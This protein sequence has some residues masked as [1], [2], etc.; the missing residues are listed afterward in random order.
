MK[1]KSTTKVFLILAVMLCFF[2]GC[3]NT[4]D[5]EGNGNSGSGGGS[6]YD[7]VCQNG[8]P[9]DGQSLIRNNNNCMACNEGYSLDSDTMSCIAP[10][11]PKGEGT[12]MSPYVLV[13]YAQL[14]TMGN[15]LNKHYKLVADI[16]ARDSWEEGEDGCDDYKG[17]GTLPTGDTPCTGWVPVGDNSDGT[18]A[19]PFTGSLDGNGYAIRGLYTHVKA[20]SGEAYGGLF[21]VTGGSAE[22]KNLGLKDTYVNV[23]NTDT[24]ASSNTY[25]GGLVGLVL[26]GTIVNSYATGFVNISNPSPSYSGGLVG[27]HRG[28]IMNSYATA[29]VSASSSQPVSGG[30]VGRNHGGSIT[31]SYAR[32]GVTAICTSDNSLEALA[33]GLVGLNDFI[34]GT[35][36]MNSYARGDVSLSCPSGIAISV[37]GGLVS[38]NNE[39]TIMNSYAVGRVG[40]IDGET[41]SEPLFG[42]LVGENTANG[43]ISGTNYFVQE[44]GGSDGVD[45]GDCAPE[46]TCARRT[47]TQL[48]ALMDVMDWAST[49]WDFGSTA[50]SPRLKYAIPHCGTTTGFACGSVIAGQ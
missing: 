1:N 14:K 22:I 30:L 7:Y 41:C 38:W 39:A 42:G 16:D 4:D 48:R 49:D 9:E 50:Q 23:S 8:T 45:R 21:G 13:N 29:K 33:G 24:A 20:A 47:L 37:G 36:I 12:E 18:D 3:G 2:P 44:Q 34:A 27:D 25:A 35:S 43:V 31:N 46:A 19:T 17:L 28:S 26:S 40:C 5:G 11:E 10:A 32:G 15:A 6:M